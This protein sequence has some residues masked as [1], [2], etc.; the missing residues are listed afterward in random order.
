MRIGPVF[1]LAGAL[2]LAPAAAWAVWWWPWQPTLPQEEAVA[3]A[4]SMGIAV[5]D[6]DPTVDADWEIEGTDASGQL[7]EL[8]LDGQTGAVEEHEIEG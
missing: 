3:I 1:A 4:M 2:S 7:I 8:I 6:I 5:S